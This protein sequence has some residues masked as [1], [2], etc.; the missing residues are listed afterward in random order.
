MLNVELK[1]DGD[2]LTAKI[3]LSKEHGRSVSGK[4]IVIGSTKG[5]AVVPGHADM[6]IGVNVYKYPSA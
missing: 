5:N 4:T 3:D 2:I 6:R 1:L